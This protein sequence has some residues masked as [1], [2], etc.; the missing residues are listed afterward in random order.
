MSQYSPEQNPE[1]DLPA[2]IAG[3]G[4]E[5]IAK[6][7]A[8]A[9]IASRRE[10]ERMIEQGRIR[11]NGKVLTQ[12][13][14][15]IG[16]SDRVEID[17]KP[18]PMAAPTQIWRYHKP[19]G[20][21]STTRDEQGR[22][23]IFDYLPHGLPRVMSVGRLDINS[24]GLLL[25]TN[26]GAL[27]RRLEHPKNGWRRQYRVRVHGRIT[28]A[29][30]D[31]LR[32]GLRIDGEQFQPISVRFERQQGANAWLFL[33]LREG[34]NR[35]IRRALEHVGLVVNRLIRV[36]YGPFE[37]GNLERGGVERVADISVISD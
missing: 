3:D 22:A 30:L 1:N 10:V 25:L 32:R 20:L 17:G 33:E 6:R 13:G 36:S 9:G 21:V 19:T 26:D 8:R 35:E 14:V 23:T 4:T 5:R 16:D 29:R 31:P 28:E 18:A 2:E 15:K 7:L 12:A 37:L 24:E 11:L 27:K 34:K